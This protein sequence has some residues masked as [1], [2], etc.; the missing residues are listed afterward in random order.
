MLVS[1]EAPL[2]WEWKRQEHFSN[3]DSLVMLILAIK[4]TYFRILPLRVPDVIIDSI[5]SSFLS[6]LLVW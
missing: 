1:Q 3:L 6:Q 5:H 4:M 2:L